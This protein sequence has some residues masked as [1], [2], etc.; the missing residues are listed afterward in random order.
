M[1]LLSGTLRATWTAVT[2]RKRPL[3]TPKRLW[4]IHFPCHET[5]QCY[6]QTGAINSVTGE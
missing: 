1:K 4:N 3:K 6:L 5:A 2:L